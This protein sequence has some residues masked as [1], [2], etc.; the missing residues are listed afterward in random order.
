[1]VISYHS[2]DEDDAY[3]MIERHP[4][5]TFVA[6]HPGEKSRMDKHLERMKQYENLFLDLSGTGLARLGV[7]AYGVR[8]AGADRFLFGTDYPI[9]NPAMYVHGVLY[10]SISEAERELICYKNAERILGIHIFEGEG[11]HR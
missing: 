7:L 11:D 8:M 6:A 2:T 1:M 9:N 5:L 4:K 10:E 3:C